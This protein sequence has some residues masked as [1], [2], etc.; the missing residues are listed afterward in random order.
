MTPSF[1]TEDISIAIYKGVTRVFPCPI[2]V[3][4][5]SL[6][7]ENLVSETMLSD[8]GRSKLIS[9]FICNESAVALKFAA[10]AFS[11]KDANVQLHE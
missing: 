1:A 3:S 8:S 7:F 6:E 10:P 4:A 11:P 9:E 5:S 2:E